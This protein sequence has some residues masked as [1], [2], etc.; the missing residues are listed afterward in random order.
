[1]PGPAKRGPVGEP[2]DHAI[3]RSRRGLTT[4]I[5]L[6][7][8][9]HCRPLAFLLTAGQAGDAPAFPD[10]MAQLRVPRP[11]GRPR[12]RPDTVLADKTYSSR[13]IREHLRKRDASTA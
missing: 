2:H 4:K 12:T 5:H 13:A 8:D 9:A 10:A 7:S 1:M 11:R 6:A 3:G